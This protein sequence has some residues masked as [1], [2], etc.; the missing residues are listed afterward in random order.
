MKAILE[1]TLPEE[2]QEYEFAMNGANYLFAIQEFDNYLRSE[3]KY[4]NE[5]SPNEDKVIQKLRDKLYE[6]LNERGV[7][8]DG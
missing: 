8:I 3:L 6:C 2:S 7:T 5:L 1:Y 4:N